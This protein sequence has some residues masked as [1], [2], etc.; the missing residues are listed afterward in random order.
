MNTE[1]FFARPYSNRQ[2]IEFVDDARMVRGPF[3]TS[4]KVVVAVGSLFIPM[5]VGIPVLAGMGVREAHNL[6]KRRGLVITLV[7]KSD[8]EQ[9]KLPPA[10]PINR[11]IYVAHPVIMEQYIPFA[12]FHRSVFEQKFN[13]L[14]TLLSHL[15]AKTIEAFHLRGWGTEFAASL[16][17]NLGELVQAKGNVKEKTEQTLLYRAVLEGHTPLMPENLKW[18]QTE[19]SWQQIADQRLHHGL[20][21]F[22]LYHR[23]VHDF[24]INA[25][26]AE[27]LKKAGFELGGNFDDHISTEWY[28]TGMF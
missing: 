13:E 6:H 3:V 12:D 22:S 18:Y 2:L 25:T 11:T 23:Y 28:V 24:G 26:I 20:Q 7:K 8:L 10:H 5:V 19:P 15:G 1:K 4:F 9:F 16:N 27:K 21:T 14:V 17:L